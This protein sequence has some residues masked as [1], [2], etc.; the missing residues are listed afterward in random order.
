MQLGLETIHQITYDALENKAMAFQRIKS[1]WK[2]CPVIKNKLAYFSE[3]LYRTRN[4]NDLIPSRTRLTATLNSINVVGPN[5]WN[6]IPPEIQC[7]Q[8][9]NSFKYQPPPVGWGKKKNKP[10]ASQRVVRGD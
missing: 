5:I 8:T 4:R 10:T 3:Y 6:S 2:I 1:V 9:K 7:L